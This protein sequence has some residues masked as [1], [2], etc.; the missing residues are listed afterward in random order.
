MHVLLNWTSLLLHKEDLS[1]TQDTSSVKKPRVTSG[2]NPVVSQKHKA[3]PLSLLAATRVLDPSAG[4]DQQTVENDA[5]LA[6]RPPFVSQ[7][8]G[9]RKVG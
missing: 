8:T 6:G 3:L 7:A 1:S 9:S 5:V 4:S 2:P